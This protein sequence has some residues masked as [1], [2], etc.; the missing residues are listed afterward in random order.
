MKRILVVEDNEA[1]LYLI[2]FI[3]ERLG[4]AVIEARD[5][6]EG[7]RLALSEKPD[8][9]LMDIQLP[10]LGGLA[11]TRRIREAAPDPKVPIIAVTSFAMPGDRQKTLGAGC[12]GYV[13]KPIDPE[14]FVRELEKYL[15]P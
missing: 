9:I 1:N 10:G 7:V 13:E 12:T 3:L 6:A 2:R 11:A 5:G 15:G 8:L 4:H 14:A